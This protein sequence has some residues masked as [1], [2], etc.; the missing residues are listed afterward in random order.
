MAVVFRANAAMTSSAGNVARR[1]KLYAARANQQ[2]LSFMAVSVFRGS[3][4]ALACNCQSGSDFRRPA[5]MNLAQRGGAGLPGEKSAMTRASSPAREARVLPR[6]ENAN[7]PRKALRGK[8][9]DL[10]ETVQAIQSRYVLLLT[11][12]ADGA[13]RS[14]VHPGPRLTGPTLLAQALQSRSLPWR[15]RGG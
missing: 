5:E 12:S 8:R 14:A 1:V 6:S 7:T 13:Q 2:C 9:N 10:D 15:N 4:R 11:P 3:A